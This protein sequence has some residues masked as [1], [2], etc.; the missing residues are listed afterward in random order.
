MYFILILVFVVFSLAMLI[1]LYGVIRC[2]VIVTYQSWK[3]PCNIDFLILNSARTPV[4]DIVDHIP[5][6]IP[7]SCL[8]FDV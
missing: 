1:F 4:L 6:I 3:L 8:Y 2:D 7:M 5:V